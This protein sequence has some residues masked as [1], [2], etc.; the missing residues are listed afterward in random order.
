MTAFSELGGRAEALAHDISNPSASLEGKEVARRRYMREVREVVLAAE[1]AGTDYTVDFG[2]L[3]ASEFP[4]G[5]KVVGINL[6]TSA[7]V[8]ESA[9]LT[10][11][12]TFNSVDVNG[13]TPLVAATLTTNTTANGGIGTTVAH[14]EYSATLSS[15]LANRVVPAGGCLSMARTH[16]STGTAVPYGSVFT[17]IF[18]R[19]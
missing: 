13:V 10:N 18:E 6:R 17:V 3:P 14:K 7:A 4:N 9:T 12:Y 16:A 1:T 19:L 15:T 8:T 5:A 2:A 11:T